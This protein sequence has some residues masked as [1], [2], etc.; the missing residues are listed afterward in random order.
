MDTLI[1]VG[2]VCVVASVFAVLLKKT[3]P[4]LSL[5]LTVAVCAVCLA[6]LTAIASE[7]MERAETFLQELGLQAELF[8]PLL[9]TLAIAIVSKTCADICRDGGQ[10]SAAGLIELAGTLSA[11]LCALPLLRILWD[12]LRG[13]L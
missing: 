4:E 9:K 8:V 5:L 2:A 11:L 13:L 10:S 6:T 12:T 3:S 1:Q 7:L